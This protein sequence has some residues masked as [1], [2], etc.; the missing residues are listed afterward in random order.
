MLTELT[1]INNNN[2]KDSFSAVDDDF[3]ITETIISPLS[4][5]SNSSTSNSSSHDSVRIVTT[6]FD[7]DKTSQNSSFLTIFLIL[8]AMVGSGILNAPQV[9]METGILVSILLIIITGYFTHLGLK[10]LIDC[11]LHCKRYDY[12]DVANFIFGISGEKLVDFSIS[13][14]SFGALMS[15]IDILGSTSEQL[16]YSWGC[17]SNFCSS[18]Y[19]TSLLILLIVLP[20]CLKRIFGH[21]AIYSVISILSI[22]AILFL[23]C[24]A[25]PIVTESDPFVPK[26]YVK[27]FTGQI[28]SIIF[29]LNCAYAS[30]HSFTSMKDPD[31]EAWSLLSGKSIIIGAISLILMGLGGY[32]SFGN[33][34]NGMI[35]NNFGGGSYDLF[36]V[37]LLIHMCLFI[38]VDFMVMRHS[39]A[40]LMGYNNGSITNLSLHVTATIILLILPAIS[41]LSFKATGI[42]EGAAFGIILDITGGIGGSLIS[43]IMPGLFYIKLKE[44]DAP[45]YKHCISMIILGIFVMLFV[46]IMSVITHLEK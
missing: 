22:T 21:L 37:L 44:K 31:S 8:N 42:N 6:G 1:S 20:I 18:Y 43:F 5:S 12:S 38:P 11:G 14:S 9:F 13:I 23:V 17:S 16:L 39:V 33:N 28:G 35:L 26:L 40:K 46:P 7:Y 36:K 4:I 24:I 15:Y 27:S 30:F 45:L 3:I 2:I 25:G 34:V 41:V 10:V 19:T 32:L 29:S